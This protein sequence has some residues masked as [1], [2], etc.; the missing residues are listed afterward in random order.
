MSSPD[1]SNWADR[2]PTRRGSSEIYVE[3]AEYFIQHADVFRPLGDS[4]EWEN[5]RLLYPAPDDQEEGGILVRTGTFYGPVGVTVE[6]YD[7][8][9]GAVRDGG[10]WEIVEETALVAKGPNLRVETNG[11]VEIELPQLHLDRGD[12]AGIRVHGRGV[13]RAAE[14]AEIR[15]RDGAIEHHLIQLWRA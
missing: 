8:P 12:A 14:V 15:L 1:A 2:R 7:S 11:G 4:T 13:E 3:K 5:G 6:T 9:A 10:E